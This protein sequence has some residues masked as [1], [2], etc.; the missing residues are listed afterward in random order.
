MAR[1]W[2]TGPVARRTAGRD[3]AWS[4]RHGHTRGSTMAR[5]P[6]ARQW[7]GPDMVF[8]YS[9][10]AVR[11]RRLATREVAALTEKVAGRGGVRVSGAVAFSR[12]RAVVGS[13]W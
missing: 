12:R 6:R 3:T 8:P 1:S 2:P 11:G 4:P 9:T 5:L 10:P 13:R 7:S